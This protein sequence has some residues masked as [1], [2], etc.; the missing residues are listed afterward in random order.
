MWSNIIK[1][2][3]F[4]INNTNIKYLC[5]IIKYLCFIGI[6]SFFSLSLDMVGVWLFG[7]TFLD[8]S[9]IDLLC[10]FL[11]VVSLY[12]VVTY[13]LPQYRR[14]NVFFSILSMF[15]ILCLL[16]LLT[17]EFNFFIIRLIQF[18]RIF[19]KVILI[20]NKIYWEEATKERAQFKKI[21]TDFLEEGD[22]SFTARKEYF[23][24]MS[25]LNVKIEKR[26]NRLKEKTVQFLWYNF[27]KIF[28]L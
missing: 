28:K 16:H 3:F 7:V 17:R 18:L 22:N 2:I 10:V 20:L 15:I 9:F 8:L 19:Y 27:K 11:F 25:D 1:I 5:F 4:Y 26:K 14:D 6:M 24:K 12:T 23:Q 21:I 13:F